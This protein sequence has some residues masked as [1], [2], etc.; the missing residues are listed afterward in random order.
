MKATSIKNYLIENYGYCKH[1]HV[2]AAKALRFV[3]K[4][5]S[6]ES[7]DVFHLVFENRPIEGAY[8]HSYGFHTNFGREIINTFSNKYHSLT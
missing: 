6:L 4:K 5:F 3:S 2:K 8:T 7:D 1:D